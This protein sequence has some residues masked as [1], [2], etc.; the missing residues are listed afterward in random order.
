[1]RIF[2]I[3]HLLRLQP[4]PGKNIRKHLTRAIVAQRSQIIGDRAVVMRGVCKDL[5]RQRQARFR[6][7]GVRASQLIEHQRVV[8]RIDDHCDALMILRRRTQHC[9]AA[10][11][12]VL[13]RVVERALGT[14]DGLLERI[15][16]D[17]ENFDRIDRVIGQR[18]HV[19][20]HPGRCASRPA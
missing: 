19:R 20:R 2:A 16:I 7:D 10:D 1:M 6:I 14:R 17:D 13:D 15:E 4:L 12:D 8:S 3:S 9:R 18:A 5:F 11:I